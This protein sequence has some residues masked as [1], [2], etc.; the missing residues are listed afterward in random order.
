MSGLH[1]PD[2]ASDEAE[3][4][5][6]LDYLPKTPG[7]SVNIKVMT[8]AHAVEEGLIPPP[9]EEGHNSFS[10]P[11]YRLYQWAH[12]HKKGVTGRGLVKLINLLKDPDFNIDQVLDSDT[13]A[14]LALACHSVHSINSESPSATAG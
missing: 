12:E 1:D 10:V 2:I 6:L 11:E 8:V 3:L 13:S 7:V 5:K 14:P 9:T 4:Q